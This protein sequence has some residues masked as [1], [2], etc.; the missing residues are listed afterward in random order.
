MCDHV[1]LT[2]SILTTGVW[3]GDV[4]SVST[5]K[6]R[7]SSVCPSGVLVYAAKEGKQVLQ[8]PSEAWGTVLEDMVNM[9]LIEICTKCEDAHSMKSDT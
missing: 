7:V 3:N 8:C 4:V 6:D 1:R 9:Y 5:K 2:Y